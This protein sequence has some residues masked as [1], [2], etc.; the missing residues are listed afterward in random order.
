MRKFLLILLKL[1]LLIWIFLSTLLQT[2]KL[3]RSWFFLCETDDHFGFKLKNDELYGRFYMEKIKDK[4]RVHQAFNKS[5]RD[6]LCGS[7]ITHID[8]E[9]VFNAKDAALKLKCLY[10]DHLHQVQ[11]VA[12]KNN[13]A[14]TGKNTKNATTNANQFSFSITFAPEKKLLGTKV[15]KSMD[16]YYGNTPGTTKKIKLK[17]DSMKSRSNV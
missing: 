3:L 14:E 13:D 6:Q 9:P 4:S 8:C 17:G 5:T 7:F 11:G 16:D 15:K 1:L 10:Q 12:E 2:K